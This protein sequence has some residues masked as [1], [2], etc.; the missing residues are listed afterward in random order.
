MAA[1]LVCVPVATTCARAS[2][3]VTK[4]PANR[5]SPTPGCSG[6]LS[7]VS[8]D[9]STAKL[10]ASSIVASADIRS[11]SEQS[12]TSP[13]TSSSAGTCCGT[14]SRNTVLRRGSISR[15]F[16]AA[17]C[18]RS[19]WAKANKPFS[20]TTR[21]TATPSCGIPAT[22]A[23][24]AATQSNKAKKW[25]VSAASRFHHGVVR[26]AGRRLAPSS[27]NSSRAWADVSPT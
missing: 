7:P 10:A 21:T 13:T 6:T 25:V 11:P 18:A 23:K 14:A 22:N 24:P 2:P 20:T 12:T 27:T 19:S 4:Q 9:V 26:C 17:C 8:A 15:S 1:S 5:L 3:S 16:S